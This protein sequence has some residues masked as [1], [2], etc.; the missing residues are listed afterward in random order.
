MTDAAA[1]ARPR[2][3][4]TPARMIRPRTVTPARQTARGRRAPPD[5]Q[6]RERPPARQTISRRPQPR[7]RR[8][9]RAGR[10]SRTTRSTAKAKASL[11]P[12]ESRPAADRLEHA[13]QQPPDHG[14]GRRVDPPE[15]GRDEALEAERETHLVG[16]ERDRDDGHPGDAGQQGAQPEGEQRDAWPGGCRPGDW[17]WRSPPPRA[18]PCR[19]ASARRRGRAAA[20]DDGGERQH[21]ELLAAD[22][23]G[24]RGRAGGPPRT[25]ACAYGTRPEQRA[26]PGPR[27]TPTAADGHHQDHQR[28]AR[29]TGATD[30]PLDRGGPPGRR[31]PRRP[32]PASGNGSPRLDQAGGD[33]RRHHRRARPARS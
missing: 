6:D 2:R 10:A 12:D 18:S 33:Q 32:A 14:P 26:G 4:R 27:S 22:D 31:R 21:P 30:A 5:G 28:A 8:A 17:P 16:D 11:K 9:G 23:G 24:G 15:H 19:R 25:A 29:R 7:R 3:R 13:E 1:R 20:I